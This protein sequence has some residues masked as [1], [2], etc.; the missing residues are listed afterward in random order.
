MADTT[1]LYTASWAG[2]A[3][4]ALALLFK[5]CETVKPEDFKAFV[6][7]RKVEGKTAL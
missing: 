4:L 2:N 1:A 5:A 7:F 3:V 6:N